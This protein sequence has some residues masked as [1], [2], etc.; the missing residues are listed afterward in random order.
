MEGVVER[1]R[2]PPAPS[3]DTRHL[4]DERRTGLEGGGTSVAGYG[5]RSG[6]QVSEIRVTT[7]K[8]TNV[9]SGGRRNTTP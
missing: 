2:D 3:S 7:G 9:G 8:G 1:S 6:V 4:V 5:R